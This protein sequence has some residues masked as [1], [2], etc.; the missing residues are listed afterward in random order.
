MVVTDD[1]SLPKT[2]KNVPSAKK[3]Q[4]DLEFFQLLRRNVNG[5]ALN[6]FYL[7]NEVSADAVNGIEY[8]LNRGLQF[9]SVILLQC[10][11]HRKNRQN[12]HC[13]RKKESEMRKRLLCVSLHSDISK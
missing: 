6:V 2:F 5:D 10:H 8:G 7:R 12:L 9:D 1:D 3:D 13:F 4:Q 11:D